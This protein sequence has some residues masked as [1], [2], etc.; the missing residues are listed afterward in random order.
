MKSL[1]ILAA[2]AVALAFAFPAFADHVV[3]GTL[4]SA[5]TTINNTTTAVPFSIK[6]ATKID[7]QCNA[8]ARIA[9]GKGSGTAA[10]SSSFKGVKEADGVYAVDPRRGFDTI[11]I[12]SPT[13]GA[14]TCVV[15]DVS[16]QS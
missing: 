14:L 9:T 12:L 11:A 7:I 16:S 1:R 15:Y 3:L 4:V 8:P 5:G 2:L 10:T 13:G 6:G